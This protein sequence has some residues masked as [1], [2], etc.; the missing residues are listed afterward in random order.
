MVRLGSTESLLNQSMKKKI[1]ILTSG[2]DAP[3]MNAA[4]RSITRKAIME[5]LE[6][7][8][9]FEGYKGILRK[10]FI[11]LNWNNVSN[12]ISEGGTILRSS[13]CM[14]FFEPS[15]RRLATFNLLSLG[16]NNLIVIGGDGS[17]KGA[18]LLSDEWKQNAS[19][20]KQTFN[21]NERQF[22]ENDE[23]MSCP[24]KLVCLIGSIDNDMFGTDFTIGADSAL[25]R[26]VEAIDNIRCTAL[27]HQRAF[28]IEVMGRKCGWL[29]L[30]TALAVEADWLFIPETFENSNWKSELNNQILYNRQKGKR[31]TIVI[32]AEGCSND[33]GDS[34]K[35]L[36][37]VS[38]LEQ[39]EL[40]TRVTTLGHVQR[41][42]KPSAFDRYLATIQGIEAIK[43]ILASDY[44]E[45]QMIA[46]CNNEILS[47]SLRNNLQ[48]KEFYE[49][50]A[51]LKARSNDFT[52]TY[53]LWK[54]LSDGEAH[55]EKLRNGTGIAI[56]NCGA[57]CAGVN[58]IIS[59][60]VKL[61]FR[62][63]FNVF[64]AIGGFYGL[65]KNDMKQLSYNDIHG[66]ISKGGSEIGMD[67]SLPNSNELFQINE[68]LIS[69]SI[70][71][72]VIIGGYES[73]KSIF[74]LSENC[75]MF[76]ALQIPIIGIPATISNNIPGS[77][78][79]IGSDTALNIITNSCDTIRQSASSSRERLF[80]V[81]VQGGFCGYLALLSGITSGASIVYLPEKGLGLERLKDDILH[82]KK[83][84]R[85]NP[86]Q[87]RLIIRNENCSD[88]YDAK[89]L[90]KIYESES[91]EL[92]DARWAILGHLQQGGMPSPL[93]RLRAIKFGSLVL[94]SIENF[95]NNN[96]MKLESREK[97]GLIGIQGAEIKFTNIYDLKNLA[98]DNVRCSV[99]KWW[100]SYFKDFLMLS[101]FH[102]SK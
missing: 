84:Y 71:A 31:A 45:P 93:D 21:E 87:G 55:P 69:H 83:R 22:E 75:S 11:V 10:D 96:T 8:G 38:N 28:V 56:V 79:S 43:V 49:K 40:D 25:N 81:D 73:F 76:P 54:L 60:L 33:R 74:L 90:A 51:P 82:I 91:E 70:V 62:K 32:L 98:D 102:S 64:G 44:L 46:I 52:E 92:F 65:I 67:R 2:G 20:Y 35:A 30:N 3:G 68:C 94:I 27:S 26:I 78:F 66:W 36:D 24:L 39:I 4:I 18:L 59:T 6:V 47:K 5:G 48:E 41:G 34:I 42:G 50:M 58:A 13:R 12:I 61:S 15:Q 95:L 7:Y 97:H 23:M 37:I 53:R 88:I 77:D 101:G 19:E 16:I 63:G 99:K 1:G 72:L 9:F 17:I 29:A 80:V 57:P 85:D 14:E 86:Q 89:T 100:L